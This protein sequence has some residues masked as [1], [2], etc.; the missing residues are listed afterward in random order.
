ML[1]RMLLFTLCASALSAGNECCVRLSEDV[2]LPS[3]P[4][5]PMFKITTPSATYYLDRSG[6]GL[7]AMIDRDG[8]DWIGFRSEPGSHA[9]GEFRGFPNAVH[10]SA[11]NYFH[12]TNKSMRGSMGVT[13]W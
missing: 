6:A 3:A 10:Q 5:L 8:N 2:T 4:G 1:P 11:G 7:A 13:T 9:A 12:P